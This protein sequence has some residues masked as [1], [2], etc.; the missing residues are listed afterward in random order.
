MNKELFGLF[1]G[2][3]AL[4]AVRDLDAFDAV[5]RGEAVTFGVRDAHLGR[6]GRTQV[7]EGPAGVCAIW[8]EA[9]LDGDGTDTARR[10][11]AAHGR[12]GRAALGDLNGSYVAVLELDG[13][14][15]VATDQL[16]SWECFHAPIRGRRAF[17][18]DLAGLLAG[19]ETPAVDRQ[20]LLE[21]LHLGTVLGERTLFES[22]DRIPFDGVLTPE[23]VEA[24]HRFVYAPEEFDY[25]S[26]LSA[27]LD[28]AIARR[29]DYAGRKGLLLSAGL[30][31][32]SLLA[33]VSDLER[34]YT[35]GWPDS[36]EA[37]VA[38]KLAAQYGATH[39]VLVPDDRYLSPVDGKVRYSQGLRESLHVHHAGYDAAIDVDVVYHGLLYDT[40]FKGYFVERDGI[41]VFGEKLPLGGVDRDVD[42]VGS[43]LDTLGFMP[44]ASVRLADCAG[45]FLGGL[46]PE[47]DLET[48][49]GT[50][51]RESLEAELRAC[52][53]RASSVPNA[54]D[55]LAVRN[56]PALSFRTHL[57]DNYVEAFVAADRELLDWHLRTPPE[58]RNPRTVRS[59]IADLDEGAFRHRAPGHLRDS[60]TLN[61]LER[62]ARRRLPFVRTV[63]PAW[64]DRRALYERYDLDRRLFPDHPGVREL[65]ARI[66]LRLNDLRWWLSTVR[67]GRPTE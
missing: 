13:R 5:V 42:P 27:R 26:E 36:Q 55:L 65:P 40:L 23:G 64:P 61:R 48:D 31:S 46:V 60:T 4:A 2:P 54:M 59:A 57:A 56:Q 45:R 58:H 6:P 17:G 49:A 33:G 52:G 63:E 1:G 38:A 14:P 16:R 39:D 25:T 9:F 34:C 51:L 11:L 67:D 18:T 47:V 50:L 7:Y 62:F 44:R 35:V 21:F 30:D 29:A 24:L 37:S 41:E 8:G 43:L 10:L 20:G 53:H 32:R 15:L 66:Q 3:P 19:V 22:V 12:R 28:R